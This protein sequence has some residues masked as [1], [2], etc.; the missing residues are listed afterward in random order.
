MKV[1]VISYLVLMGF[2][3]VIASIKAVKYW[4]EK[5]TNSNRLAALMLAKLTIEFGG[6]GI[7]LW[8]W[9]S[10]IVTAWT[11]FMVGGPTVG[12]FVGTIVLF[13]NKLRT[14]KYLPDLARL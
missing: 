5:S 1:V 14:G 4:R 10:D 11:I 9:S 8:L 2:G 12:V 7:A 13:E 3:G 6:L